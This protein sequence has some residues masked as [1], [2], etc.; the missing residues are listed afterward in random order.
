MSSAK[1]NRAK[2]ILRSQRLLIAIFLLFNFLQ[3]RGL[4]AIEEKFPRPTG[5]I[6]DFASIIPPDTKTAMEEP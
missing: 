4:N 1:N 6:N 5:A 3:G 2:K